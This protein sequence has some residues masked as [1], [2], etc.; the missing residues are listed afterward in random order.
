M[1][2]CDV[3]MLVWNDAFHFDGDNS[4]APDDSEQAQGNGDGFYSDGQCDAFW[5]V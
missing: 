3:K 4:V 2:G 1:Y 5:H